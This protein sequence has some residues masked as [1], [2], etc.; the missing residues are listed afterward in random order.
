MSR[1]LPATILV[2][3]SL[4]AAST[5]VAPARAQDGRKVQPV[6]AVDLERYAGRWYEL[7]RFPNRFQKRC[8]GDV[9]VFYAT[10]PDGRI[11][12]RNTCET[13]KGPIEAKGIARRASADGPPSVLQVRFAPAFLSWLPQ[14]WGD[15]WILDL[16]P[17]YSTAV[18]G[19]PDREYLWLLSRLPEVDQPTY[20]RM[21]Q[22]ARA[23]GFNEGRLVR[24]PQTAE[25]R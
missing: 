16:A 20:A 8:T 3:S 10:R 24:T 9:A 4:L 21:V 23:Q 18:V 7:A 15:Y 25:V 17:D 2:A 1:F 6:P 12:V 11:D 5:V 19:T 14:V 13:A 22:A